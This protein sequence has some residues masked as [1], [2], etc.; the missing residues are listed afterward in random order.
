MRRSRAHD[1]R[2]WQAHGARPEVRGKAMTAIGGLLVG[3]AL[4]QAGAPAAPPSAASG[5][6][7]LTCNMAGPQ[8]PPDSPNARRVFRIGRGLFQ[9]WRPAFGDFSPNLCQSFRCV[10]SPDRLEGTITSTSLTLTITVDM[11]ARAAT[12]RT[13]GASGLRVPS[14]P[15]TMEPDHGQTPKS[16]SARPTG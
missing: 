14:G 5:A 7:I 9:Q 8:E 4:A 16:P 6:W 2:A 1:G 11:A 13:V 12:W 10:S 3:L 15:C